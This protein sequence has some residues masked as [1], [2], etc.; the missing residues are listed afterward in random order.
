MQPRSQFGT[1]LSLQRAAP[2][3]SSRGPLLH[4]VSP[5][6][7]PF[8]TFP[9][10]GLVH[11]AASHGLLLPRGVLLE[12]RARGSACQ[13]FLSP[14][15]RTLRAVCAHPVLLVRAPVAGRWGCCGGA[16]LCAGS[17]VDTVSFVSGT[18]HDGIAGDS[19]V[20]GAATHSSRAV[21]S[22]PAGAPRTALP[23]VG[24]VSLSPGVLYAA[25]PNATLR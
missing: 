8:G 18:A 4:L 13:N 16:C 17:C 9:A 5:W 14:H 12:V 23:R 11:H 1:P 7:C 21:P 22:P 2:R 24:G 19:G 20:G 15:G 3:P 10:K 25:E 6:T